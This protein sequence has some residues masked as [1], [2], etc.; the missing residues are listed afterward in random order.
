MFRGRQRLWGSQ[1]PGKLLGPS[2]FLS[3]LVYTTS[4]TN[5]SNILLPIPPDY[6][7]LCT[8]FNWPL[9]EGQGKIRC[10]LILGVVTE[11]MHIIE[12]HL[13][14]TFPYFTCFYPW[15]ELKD[16]ANSQA[17]VWAALGNVWGVRRLRRFHGGQRQ[18]ILQKR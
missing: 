17:W 13:S 4:S 12:K 1:G 9:F 3:L 14:Q 15:K 7:K 18:Q 8:G 11:N 2:L 6:F 5:M 10:A 16:L